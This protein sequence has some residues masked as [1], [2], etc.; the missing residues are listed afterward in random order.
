MGLPA[1]RL[2]QLRGHNGKIISLVT[3]SLASAS[4]APLHPRPNYHNGYAGIYGAEGNPS[5][6][7]VPDS[8][9]H[10]QHNE[11]D[12]EWDWESV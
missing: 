11:L 10:N 5:D 9:G 4:E 12:M 6:I 7:A 3:T 8:R 2:P 1:E